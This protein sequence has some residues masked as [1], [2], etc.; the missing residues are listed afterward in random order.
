[1]EHLSA[2]LLTHVRIN[3]F[4]LKPWFLYAHD[5]NYGSL[6]HFTE[7]RMSYQSDSVRKMQLLALLTRKGHPF[8]KFLWGEFLLCF[9]LLMIFK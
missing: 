8:G 1:M 5:Y 3:H 7:F 4:N 6:F 2:K 9:N